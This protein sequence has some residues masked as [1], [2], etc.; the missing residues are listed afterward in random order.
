M[1]I[2]PEWAPNVHPM[3][4]H[5]PIALLC[6]AVLLDAVALAAR[7]Q[8]GL[9]I[10]AILVYVLGTIGALA[11]YL[12]GKDAGDAVLLSGTAN[13]ALTD[14][15][16]WATMTVWFFGIY[17]LVRLGVL[18]WDREG[19]KVAVW[20]PLLL[21]GAGGLFLVYQTAEHG[22]QMVFEHGVGVK[23]MADLEAQVQQQKAELD[24]SRAQ[25]EGPEIDDDGSWRWTPGA[26]AAEAFHEAFTFR[27][28]AAGAETWA[29]TDE[30]PAVALEATGMPALF[31][32][33]QPLRS[34]QAD[35]ALNLDDFDGALQIVHHVQDSLTYL[36]TEIAAGMMRQGRMQNGQADI[37][38]EKPFAGQGWQ[39]VR[40]VADRTHFRAYAGGTL[41]THGHGPAPE[42]GPVGLRLDGTGTFLLG[43][44][45]V[46]ALR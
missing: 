9:R 19:K 24:R 40:V 45:D 6:A 38:D 31:V 36:F 39:Q 37:M 2:M 1:D 4:V 12:T 30:G 11:S 33:D 43:R 21:I 46:Q 10:A 7:K 13:T 14:H 25:A 27:A 5:F 32:F 18:W 15:A 20:V 26:Y 41:I 17:A 23:A 8:A 44:I 42:P 29:E 22:A 16:D 3:L 35:L 28:G 34:L